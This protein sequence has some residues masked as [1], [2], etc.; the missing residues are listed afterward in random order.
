MLDFLHPSDKTGFE[1]DFTG[2]KSMYFDAHPDVQY[3]TK[4]KNPPVTKLCIECTITGAIKLLVFRYTIAMT[5]P[6][7]NIHMLDVIP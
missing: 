5:A 6:L 3:I 1:L 2:K 4:N 7:R